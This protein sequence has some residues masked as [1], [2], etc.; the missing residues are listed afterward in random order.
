MVPVGLKAAAANPH[1]AELHREGRLEFRY[2][3]ALE[4]TGFTRGQL[5]AIVANYV[6]TVLPVTVLHKQD[7]QFSEK[8]IALTYEGSRRV[9][10]K[11]L[12]ELVRNPVKTGLMSALRETVKYVPIKLE[13]RFKNVDARAALRET[14]NHLTRATFT[15]PEGGLQCF[16][17][18]LPLMAKG[19]LF[20]V[21][22]KAYARTLDFLHLHFALAATHGNS[23][24]HGVNTPLL[25]AYLRRRHH[26]ALR[27]ADYHY[28]TQ[29][30]AVLNKAAVTPKFA[31]VFDRYYVT[32]NYNEEA[33]SAT[34]AARDYMRLRRW[35]EAVPYLRRALRWRPGDA[36]LLG[37]LGICEVRLG[38]ERAGRT[39]IAQAQARDYFGG[40]T[41]EVPR[42]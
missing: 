21:S 36:K 27:T 39:L 14:T 30:L 9:T 26:G 7:D 33:S 16:D 41:D 22:D 5:D 17:A 38:H 10:R 23:L 19:G 31:Q 15:Y 35:S 42:R 28:G 34:S 1:L 29:T 25:E 3:D 24:S 4:P 40:F 13:R 11:Q 20:V 6:F 2:L 8:Y 37:R 32:T 12:G 18:L